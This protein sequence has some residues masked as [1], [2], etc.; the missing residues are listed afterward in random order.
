[1]ANVPMARVQFFE[2]LKKI[3]DGRLSFPALTTSLHQAM[4]DFASQTPDNVDCAERMEVGV[5]DASIGLKV[6]GRRILFSEIA[7]AIEGG[8]IP[9][10]LKNALPELTVPE[11]EAFARMTTLLY[12]MLERANDES[13]DQ[14]PTN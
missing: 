9:D 6:K 4:L 10:A 2:A 11:W 5:V 7:H 14:S 13:E 8:E 3:Q 12:V 1:M